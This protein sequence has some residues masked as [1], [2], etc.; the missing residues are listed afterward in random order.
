MHD[1]DLILLLAIGFPVALGF[2]Y[3]TERMKLSPIVGYLLAGIVV[4]PFTPGFVADQEIITQLAEIGVI[5]LMFGVGLHFRLSDLLAVRRVA[6]PGAIAQI[7]ISTILGAILAVGFGWSITSG[8]VLGVALA[9]ASTVVLT[10]VLTDN[11]MLDTPHGHIAIG[12][13][14]V[15]DL[16]TILVLVL[17]PIYSTSMKAGQGEGNALV[18]VGLAVLRLSVLTAIILVAGKRFIPWLLSQV[19]R[20]RSRE[21][22]TLTVL[23]LAIAIATISATIFGASF[24]L[25]AFL[26]GMVVGQTKVGHQAAADAL[27]MRDAFAVL[28]FISVGM[29]FDPHFLVANPMLVAMVLA[30]VL[31][32]KPL[33]ALGIVLL[34][35]YSV[36]AALTVSLALAQVGEFTFILSSA[37]LSLGVFTEEGQHALIAAS[38]ISIALNPLIFRRVNWI[39]LKLRKSKVLWTMLNRRSDAQARKINQ[40]TTM[41]AAAAIKENHAIVVGYG[42]V[43]QTVT[44]ILRDFNIHPTVIELNI[45]TV[46]S[47]RS[48]AGLSALFGDAARPEILTAAGIE[49][50]KFL[51]LTVPDLVSRIPMIATARELNPHIMILVRARYLAEQNLLEELGAHVI[52]FEEA[53]AAVSLSEHLL[54]AVGIEEALIKEESDKIRAELSGVLSPPEQ[55]QA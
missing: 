29:L 40:E 21:L 15:E 48:T 36:R 43:G 31:I 10:R 26:A 24:A 8:I 55:R 27:P 12:W 44:R 17:L 39:E 23:A 53:E 14:I 11:S 16:F 54:R 37:A 9:V 35:G 6:I 4:G 18:V 34:L 38:L 49:R 28:F 30:I 19:A 22:F 41:T 25:G 46:H 5:L 47:L 1:Y 32:A 42:P 2:G 3:I 33:A 52:S 13:L 20:T 45:D 51:L 50:A 7:T